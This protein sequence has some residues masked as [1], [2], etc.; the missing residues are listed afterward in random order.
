MIATMTRR[1][2]TLIAGLLLVSTSLFAQTIFWD[3]PRTVS[4]GDAGFPE[5]REYAGG[6]AL[7]WQDYVDEVGGEVQRGTIRVRYALSQNGVAWD[8]GEESVGSSSYEGDRVKVYDVAIQGRSAVVGVSDLSESIELF[9]TTSL[10]VRS[11]TRVGTVTKGATLTAPTFA[12]QS[13]GTYR[14]FVSTA[15]STT[16][17]LIIHESISSNG[18]NW[19]AFTPLYIPSQT[20]IDEERYNSSTPS[21]L[22]L[23]STPVVVFQK[24]GA[25]GTLEQLFLSRWNGE[26]WDE[27][28]RLT[29][30][31]N[32]ERSPRVYGL[33]G[34]RAGLAWL[35]DV[36]GDGVFVPKYAELTTSGIVPGTETLVSQAVGPTNPAFFPTF[37]DG[38][39]GIAWVEDQGAANVLRYAQRRGSSWDVASVETVV[40]GQPYRLVGLGY[41]GEPYLVWED[42]TTIAERSRSEVRFVTT[43]RFVEQLTPR[44]TNFTLGEVSR[45]SSFRFTWPIPE[46]A[47]T[48]RAYS[49][50]VDR[51]PNADAPRRDSE[52][53]NQFLNSVAV[54]VPSDGVW[55]FHVRARD[56]AGNWSETA[57]LQFERDRTPPEAAAIAE[58][59]TDGDGFLSSNTG[60]L[61]WSVPEDEDFLGFGY[62]L[63]FL[64]AQGF[65]ADQEA[66]QTGLNIPYR[67]PAASLA[68]ENIDNGNYA[69]TVES[70]DLLG[71]A[72][73][74]ATYFFRANK[75]IPVTFITRA[76]A[77]VSDLGLTSL[78][79]T[80]RGF[81]DVEGRITRIILDRDRQE[82]YDID[83]DVVTLGYDILG[84]RFI[85]NVAL[86]DV[87]ESGQYFIGVQHSLRGLAW[88]PAA[89][90]LESTGIIRIGDFAFSRALLFSPSKPVGW[91]F[92]ATARRSS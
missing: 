52:L 61:E 44:P 33:G 68:F 85:G 73:N 89:L 63:T 60:T 50:S 36:G 81:D 54:E 46:D 72:G 10:G 70:V 21:F 38:G 84:D 8:V 83:S 5:L 24:S 88:S 43:D 49:Y 18:R 7:F 59:E 71:N 28:T 22:E 42:E 1:S 57:T 67:G 6:L 51:N 91:G 47:G 64:G 37:F 65:P 26:T 32:D 90:A 87:D 11:F 12:V 30:N 55:Y 34:G 27:P 58:L 23:G 62:T 86:E 19:S 17:R 13:D 56:S 41:R 9:R 48:I 20:E 4:D 69:L 2:F 35:S 25:V 3:L 14:M 82:P 77:R 66:F 80:G 53:S 31:S 45:N 78:E 92:S 15:Y 79:L 29:D 75:Y 74:R 16:N 40:G 76:T 39:R